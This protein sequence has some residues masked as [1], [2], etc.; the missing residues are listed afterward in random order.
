[1]NKELTGKLIVLE[2]QH[3]NKINEEVPF[4]IKSMKSGRDSRLPDFMLFKLRQRDKQ[5]VSRETFYS[6]SN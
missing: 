5:N 6:N 1:M 2:N 3:M 4:K